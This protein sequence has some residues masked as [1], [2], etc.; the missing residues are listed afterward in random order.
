[1][2]RCKSHSSLQM[3]EKE[4]WKKYSILKMPTIHKN[5]CNFSYLYNTSKFFYWNSDSLLNTLVLAF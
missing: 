3:S 5:K 4:N 1:M 2:K